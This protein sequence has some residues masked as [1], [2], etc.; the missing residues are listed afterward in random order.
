MEANVAED[1]FPVDIDDFDDGHK[2]GNSATSTRIASY[3]N[4][5][6][7]DFF[8]IFDGLMEDRWCAQAFD[9]AIQKSKPWGNDF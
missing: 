8:A 4:K 1:I 5:S 3:P 9:Y 7:A 6:S 2:P